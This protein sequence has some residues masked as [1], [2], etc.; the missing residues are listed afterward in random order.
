MPRP[1]HDAPRRHEAVTAPLRGLAAVLFVFAAE[2]A[3]AQWTG[4]IGAVSDYRHRGVSF[5]D[6][7]PAAQASAAYDHASGFFAG[8]Q[9]TSVRLGPSST[10]TNV[11]FLAYGGFAQNLGPVSWEAGLLRY[12]YSGPARV[13]RYDYG[14]AFVGLTRGGGSARV[15][16]S[17]RHYENDGGSWYAQAGYAGALNDD[18]QFFVQGGVLWLS[19]EDDAAMNPSRRH[20][21]ARVGLQM[22]WRGF[23][24]ELALAATDRTAGHCYGADRRCDFG[25][26]LSI[27]RPLP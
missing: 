27:S 25:P 1:S 12:D 13:Q 5:S 11:E 26:V 23:Q 9:A 6:R 16:R 17:T 15:F 8:G 4:A 19:A 18:L 24:F 3:C 21:D 22:L 10:G 2:G 7:H 20:A 14:E